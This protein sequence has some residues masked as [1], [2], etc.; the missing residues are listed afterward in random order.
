MVRVNNSG[1]TVV[2]DKSGG[3]INENFVSRDEVEKIDENTTKAIEML[4]SM[5]GSK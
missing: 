1:K 5:A 3:G 2:A 4:L